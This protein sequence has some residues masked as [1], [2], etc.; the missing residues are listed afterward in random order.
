MPKIT[1]RSTPKKDDFPTPWTVEALD[2][3]FKVSG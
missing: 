3:S 2:G 1:M